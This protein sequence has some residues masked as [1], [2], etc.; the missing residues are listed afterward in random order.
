[1]KGRIDNFVFDYCGTIS[2]DLL[3]VYAASM[4]VFRMLGLRKLSLEE[5]QRTFRV[6]YMTFYRQF[7]DAPKEEIDTLFLQGLSL[8]ARPEPFPEIREAL[9][10]L[11]ERDK[12]LAILS[13]YPQ[14]TLREDLEY[15]GLQ[16]FFLDVMG[17]VHDKMEGIVA[18]MKRNG[19][20]PERTAIVG[21]MDYDIETGKEVGATTIAVSRD[22]QTKER[23]LLAKPDFF[24][25]K[26]GLKEIEEIIS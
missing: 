23:L 4:F 10:F 26:L 16:G 17:S 18:L 11:K 3:Q 14:E 21:D 7:T 2:N 24:L 8:Q 22:S 12:K 19:F 15:Y 13:S 6:P 9:E 25:E 5:F 20:S 1:M